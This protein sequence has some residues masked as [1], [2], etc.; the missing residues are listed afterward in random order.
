MTLRRTLLGRVAQSRPDGGFTLVEL[1]VV[2]VLMGVGSTIA[3]SGFQGYARSAEHSGTRND[4]SSALRAAHQRAQS[5]ATSYCVSFA[6]DGKSWS[7]FRGAC[8]TGQLVKGPED[9]GGAEVTLTNVSFLRPDGTPGSRD[10]TFTARGTASKGSL[11]VTRTGSAK[12]YTVSVEGMTARV[13]T[14]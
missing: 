13:S 4:V 6:A 5:E 2:V 7:T 3:V 1:L 10:V 12:T 11:T 8:G 14:S 9:V